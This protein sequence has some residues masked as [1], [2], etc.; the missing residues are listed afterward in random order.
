[1]KL[2]ILL[3][4]T[5]AL[6]VLAV[7]TLFADGDPPQG[8]GSAFDQPKEGEETPK[9]AEPTPKV[10]T[11]KDY[12]LEMETKD[13]RWWTVNDIPPEEVEKGLALSITF[14]LP[15]SPDHFD[16]RM[17]S[18]GW[19][20]GG[21]LSFK[22]GTEIGID[23]YK[24]LCEKFYEDDLKEWKELRDHEKPKKVKMANA[25]KTAYRYSF[26]GLLQAAGNFPL[27][28]QMY[29]FKFKDRTY[30]LQILFTTTSIKNE[31]VTKEVD[32]M[33]R[34]MREKPERR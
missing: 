17:I 7:P 30:W 28:K 9:E 23:N 6:L 19:K 22:D 26:T 32:E 20:V 5:G 8:G 1:M 13:G 34:S 10:F 15:K 3:A 11:F 12:R 16:V 2:P 24:M 27:H 25:M 4:L 21:K 29:F 33:L 31:R 14:K 18:Q